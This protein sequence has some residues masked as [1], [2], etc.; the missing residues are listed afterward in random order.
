MLLI[1]ISLFINSPAIFLCQW[2][3]LEFMST[4]LHYYVSLAQ[5]HPLLPQL[6]AIKDVTQPSEELQLFLEKRFSSEDEDKAL[7]I[8]TMVFITSMMSQNG[9]DKSQWLIPYL[10][11]LRDLEVDAHTYCIMMVAK[12]C[13][14]VPADFWLYGEIQAMVPELQSNFDLVTYSQIITNL[15]MNYWTLDGV[16][17][18]LDNLKRFI[19]IGL[20]EVQESLQV[21]IGYLLLNPEQPLD[22]SLLSYV[23]E[24]DWKSLPEPLHYAVIIQRLCSNLFTDPWDLTPRWKELM[25]TEDERLLF[26][27]FAA[28]SNLLYRASRVGLPGYD[29]GHIM[30]LAISAQDEESEDW[31]YVFIRS[32]F[33]L[34]RLGYDE[35]ELYEFLSN[36]VQHENENLMEAF[37]EYL[38]EDLEL[39]P[40][41]HD[42]PVCKVH[43]LLFEYKHTDG[44]S[45]EQYY[46]KGLGWLIMNHVSD[47]TAHHDLLV[48]LEDYREAVMDSG[49]DNNPG[50]IA[51]IAILL[52]LAMFYRVDTPSHWLARELAHMQEENLKS[53][54]LTVVFAE[55]QPY[56]N[57]KY[58][59]MYIHELKRILQL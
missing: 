26:Q 37:A 2:Y 44:K 35:D 23:Y 20:P 59:C 34:H 47:I 58:D 5:N 39:F 42:K 53:Y 49:P 3:L 54:G 50:I 33:S 51:Y 56:E 25:Q 30:D 41:H 17:W 13:R 57:E 19:P 31:Q 14:N 45:F 21:A 12:G 40:L 24:L 8:Q 55:L 48:D 15:T 18:I 27:A 7:F 22:P 29:L 52:K 1:D 16:E 43:A 11:D 9:S 10:N 6:H 32:L 36:F 28:I 46:P 38:I 4:K